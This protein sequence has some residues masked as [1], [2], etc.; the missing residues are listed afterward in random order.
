MNTCTAG[1]GQEGRGWLLLKRE[2]GSSDNG[3]LHDS[4]QVDRVSTHLKKVFICNDGLVICYL[5]NLC[6]PSGAA[7][8]LQ[9]QRF[10]H[11]QHHVSGY[12]RCNI[13]MQYR[14]SDM[15]HLCRHTCSYVGWETCPAAYPT[16][17]L[18]TPFTL[19]RQQPRQGQNTLCKPRPRKRC[20]AVH[21][22]CLKCN[23][24]EHRLRAP[25]AAHAK[26][27]NLCS[28]EKW[29]CEMWRELCTGTLL[30][31]TKGACLAAG[32]T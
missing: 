14:Q 8:N 19:L 32:V 2:S 31:S 4:S 21:C 6:M 16:C 30:L 5:Y 10:R 17:V 25:E 3:A 11:E 20:A 28:I 9:A 23:L 22:R 24:L 13:K 15:W 18:T 27:C 1:N 29:Q 12:N 26:R 7:A